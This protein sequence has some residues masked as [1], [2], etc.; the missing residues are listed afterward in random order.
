MIREE[1]YITTDL[2]ATPL[3][4]ISLFIIIVTEQVLH[5]HSFRI[6]NSAWQE[7]ETAT[8][9]FLA[10]INNTINQLQLGWM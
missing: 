3:E 4:L 8:F 1:N 6:I 2:D 10:E 9:K 7:T 5:T